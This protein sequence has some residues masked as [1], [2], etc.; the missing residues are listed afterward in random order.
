[1]E[2]SVKFKGG[3]HKG[4]PHAVEFEA[5]LNPMK[6]LRQ[7]ALGSCETMTISLTYSIQ[8]M[9]I[10]QSQVILSLVLYLSDLKVLIAILTLRKTCGHRQI[11]RNETLLSCVY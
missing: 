6:S 4:E 1:M 3:D 7:N 2:S 9:G 10:P 8:L 11:K 5:E